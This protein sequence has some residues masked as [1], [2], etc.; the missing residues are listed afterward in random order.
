[1]RRAA[2]IGALI[3]GAAT[4]T[5]LLA[6][7]VWPGPVFWVDRYWDAAITTGWVDPA[8]DAYPWTVAVDWSPDGSTIA[9]GGYHHDVLLWDVASGALRARLSGHRSWVQEVIWFADGA[10]IASA[11]WDGVV[12]VWDVASGQPAATL[13]AGDETDVF[14]VGVHPTLPLI[15]A[16]T[17]AGRTFVLDWQTEEL[18]AEIESNPGGTLFATFT[19]DGAELVTAGEDGHVRFFA[20]G[21]W[22]ETRAI[23]AHDAGI[24]SVSFTADGR[25]ML[26]GGDDGM[27][28][29]WDLSSGH[30]RGAWRVARGW[31]NFCCLLPDGER[32]LTAG[33]DG[34]IGVW[35]TDLDQAAA[36]LH[37]HTDWAQCVRPSRDGRRFAST[38]KEGTIQIYDLAG[39]R[40]LREIDVGPAVLAQPT[41]TGTPFKG[42]L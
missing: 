28:R 36:E 35:R 8:A 27:V 15:A 5:A 33:T 23:E 13:Q 29:L 3:G 30:E 2:K 34:R 4:A 14:G 38:G 37:L 26:S 11:D 41:G 7:F 39:D 9:S 16:G 42:V 32:F 10:H 25:S 22:T 20:T 17:Y 19:P 40:L 6:W 31:V 18:V 21:S 24:T 12:I 1:V